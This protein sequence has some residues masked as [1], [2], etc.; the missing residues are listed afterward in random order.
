M[1]L[2]ELVVPPAVEPI[3]LADAKA[4]LRIPLAVTYDDVLISALITA[5]RIECEKELRQ[6][7]ITTQWKLHID[8]FP[9][10]GGYFNRLIRQMGEGPLWLPQQGGGVFQIPR[11]PFVSIQAITYVDSNATTQTI[12]STLYRVSPGSPGRVQPVYGQVWPIAAPVIDA[13]QILFTA[14][15][16][17]DGTFV[18]VNVVLAIKML[19]A[20]YYENREAAADIPRGI[21]SILSGADHGSYA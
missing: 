20:H 13:V 15:Y 6:S 8:G 11:P 18:P 5:A 12:S 4:H 1:E 17:A 3:L 16:G 7:F 14:G 21:A 10:G 19:V 2:L 9:F